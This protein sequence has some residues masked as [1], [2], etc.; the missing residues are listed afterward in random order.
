MKSLWRLIIAVAILV[1]LG[2][3]L[4]FPAKPAKSAAPDDLVTFQP[5]QV[6]R[7]QVDRPGQ[8]QVILDRDHGQWRLEQPYPAAADSGAVSTLLTTASSIMPAEKLGA[9][10]KLAPFGLDQPAS[11]ALQLGNG[12]TYTFL[13]GGTSPTSENVYL[14]LASSPNVYTVPAYVKT[15]LEQTAFALQDKSLLDFDADQVS[16]VTLQDHGRTLTFTR[17]KGAWPKAEASNLND[18]TSAFANAEMDAMVSP[19][20]TDPAKYG[21]VNP[22]ITV[23]FAW[24]D[25][26]GEVV[27]G[28]KK[29]ASDYY[30]RNGDDPAIYT[31]NSYLLDDIHSLAKPAKPQAA[32]K[33]TPRRAEPRAPVAR[34]PAPPKASR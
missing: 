7:V 26:S 34:K 28:H 11:V 2:L 23:Q 18:L 30:A 32:A 14:K 19:Q 8:P 29:G 33:K 25:G 20:G 9:V 24:P 1:A 17:T 5:S 16:R 13:L 22:P 31:V 4:R 21:L 10:Q 3:Y 15:D 27:I 12:K 6:N